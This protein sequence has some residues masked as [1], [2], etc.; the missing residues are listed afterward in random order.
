M[1]NILKSN[2]NHTPNR[3]TPLFKFSSE[4]T[5]STLTIYNIAYVHQEKSRARKLDKHLLCLKFCVDSLS[6]SCSSFKRK[7]EYHV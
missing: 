7:I 4:T 3:P 1:K 6:C 2:R 5:I